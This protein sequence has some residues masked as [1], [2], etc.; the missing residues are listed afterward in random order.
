MDDTLS[1]TLGTGSVSTLGMAE[2]FATFANGGYHRE[3]VA[4]T[5]IDSRDGKVLYQ[6][7]D[8]PEQALTT[9][10]A[11]AVTQ[12]LEG[13]MTSGTGRSGNPWIDQPIAGKT[14]TAG[15]AS[16][17]TDLWFCGYSPQYAVSIWVGHSGSNAAIYGLHT[18]EMVLP[19]FKTFMSTML[20][21]TAR[22]E[23]PTGD[24]PEYKANSTWTFSKTNAKSEK[25]Q[26]QGGQITEEGT[27]TEEQQS[28]STDTSGTGNGGTDSG[29]G[30]TDNSGNNSGTDSGN[31]G[32]DG[33]TDSG[34]G[35][36]GNNGG[37]DNGGTVTPDPP[38]G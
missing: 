32:T 30:G 20:S 23:F 22:E 2:A 15:T 10:Q 24:A 12:V 27:V 36:S 17:T 19:V 8:A 35:G 26:E 3:S 38:T 16:E 37:T 28:D 7:Q 4:I 9:G 1:M 18:S 5:E 6:H 33:G 34:S 31:G 11:E 25:Q 13:V 29:S 14:G 21:G